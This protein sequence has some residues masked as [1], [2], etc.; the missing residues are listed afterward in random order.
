[1]GKPQTEVQIGAGVA[2]AIRIGFAIIF[3]FLV[4]VPCR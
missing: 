3:P 2:W 4:I 1:M